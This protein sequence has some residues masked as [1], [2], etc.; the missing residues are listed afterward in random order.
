MWEPGVLINIGLTLISAGAVYGA[1]R[2]DLKSLHKTNER[3]HDTNKVLFGKCELV[4][5]RINDHIEH[6]HMRV[7]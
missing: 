1:I 7:K 4:D 5:R 2:A 6:H 3:Q